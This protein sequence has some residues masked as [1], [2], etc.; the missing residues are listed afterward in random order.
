[1][2]AASNELQCPMTYYTNLKFLNV[3]K[4]IEV[5][6]LFNLKNEGSYFYIDDKVCQFFVCNIY[7]LKTQKKAAN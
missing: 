2:S 3:D 5:Y 7:Y 6:K 1:M 4:I